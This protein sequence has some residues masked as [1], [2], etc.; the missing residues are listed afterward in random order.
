VVVCSMSVIVAR[1]RRSQ[2]SARAGA[3]A[4][5]SSPPAGFYQR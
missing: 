3:H 1:R 5:H 4:D 2:T